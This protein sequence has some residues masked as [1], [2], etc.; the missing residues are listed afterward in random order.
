M[1]RSSVE[2]DGL[3]IELDQLHELQRAY[4]ERDAAEL[5][6]THF[7]D[8][9]QQIE[10]VRLG[11]ELL[12]KYKNL[13]EKACARNLQS[14]WRAWVAQGHRE[15]RLVGLLL[16]GGPGA[17]PP[18]LPSGGGGGAGA[19]AAVLEA[20][21]LLGRVDARL[22]RAR[23]DFA[24]VFRCADEDTPRA[25]RWEPSRASCASCAPC[26]STRLGHSSSC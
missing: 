4:L 3:G 13:Y 23:L 8:A 17:A 2:D 9:G 7:P 1:G 18:S 21:S 6:A 19:A 25:C 15:S 11:Q 16:G 24:A 26:R 5:L 10:L 14:S 22:R 20:R 12:K